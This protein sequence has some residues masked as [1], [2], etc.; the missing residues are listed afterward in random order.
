M[1]KNLFLTMTLG[2]SAMLASAQPSYDFSKMQRESLGRGVIA[3]RQDTKSVF[4][5][6]RYLEQDCKETSFNVYREGKL[7]NASPIKDVTWF[8]D[9]NDSGEPVR[10][11]VRAVVNGKE[12]SA[13]GQNAQAN[14][15]TFTLPVDAPHG[16][17]NLPL[18]VPADGQTPDGKIY[19]YTPNDASIGDVDGDGEYEIILKWDPSNAHD[20]AH[21]GYT[22]NVLFDCYK[23]TGE[24]LWRIDLGRNVRAGAHYTQF[25][26]YDFDGDGRA[27]VIM[28]TG[29]GTKD[30]KGKIIG[31]ANANWVEPGDPN[32]VRAGDFPKGD[33]RG[34]DN[35]NGPMRNQGR[36]LTGPEYL[37]VFN[38]KTG[39]AMAT[40]DYVPARGNL[41]DWGDERANRSDRFLAAVA[42][43]DGVHPS[44]VM[45][46]G[47]YTR[48]VL[49]AWDWDG[50]QLKQRWVFDSYSN[51]Y[52]DYSGQGN[53]NLRVG[54]VDGDGC[55]EILYGACAI[56]HNGQGLYS[57]KM[58]HGDAMHLTG[59][60]PG[61]SHLQVWDCHE[62]RRD[63][64][65]LHDAA[66]GKVL[67]QIPSKM[68]VGRAMAADIDPTNYGVEMWTWDSHGIRNYKGDSIAPCPGGFSCNSAVWWDGDLNRELF[69]RVSREDNAAVLKY[70]AQTQRLDTLFMIEGTKTINGTKGVPCL[71]GDLFG[72][73]REE[74]LLRSDDNRSL[75]LYVST[76]PTKYRFHSFLSD[77]VYRISIATQ[78][79]AYNQPTQPGFYFG[80]DLEGEFRGTTVTKQN[81]LLAK[82]GL[83]DVNGVRDVTL[84]SLNLANTVR[85]VAGSSRKGN[86]PVLFLVGNSTMRTGTLGNGN[87]G[88]WGWGYFEHEYFDETKIT[89]ENHALGGMS[90]RTFYRRLWP[91]VLKGVQAGDYVII[92]LG[93]NDNGP[94]DEGRARASIPGVGK[95]SLVVT[96]KETGE[97]ETVYTYGEYLRRYIRE[98]KSKGAHPIIFS[99]TPRNSWDNETTL[100]RKWDTF[101]PWGKQVAAE[102]GVPHIDLEAI[103]AQKFEK[104]GPA[105]VNYMFYLDKIHTSEFGARTNARSAAEGIAACS[106]SDLRNYLLP[107]DLPMA[108]VQREPGKPVLFLCGDSTMKN[109]DKDEDGMW[110]W[111][112]VAD[113]AFD[114][115]KITIANCGMA[116]RS[117][118]TFLDEGRWDKVYNALQPGD[119]VVIQFGHNDVGD[120]NVK[121]AR[122]VIRG[123]ADS[124][125][126]YSMEPTRKYQVIYTFG[127]Y[128]RKFIGDV[129]EKGATP[130][131]VSLT[132]R[133]E[134]PDGKIERRNDSYGQWFR[135][136]VEQ[137]GVD[138][139]DVHNISAD[140]L[141][142][143]GKEKAKA[144]YNT[145]H[146]HTSKLGAQNNAQS[147]AKGLRVL[148]HPLAKYLK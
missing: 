25:M 135:E 74:L 83:A 63:G 31:D 130:I 47:Y 114:P 109:A 99:L 36:I 107:L 80:S 84:D 43:L 117:T 110:G 145:D 38:G 147:L 46:R 119:F 2:A 18:Q 44:A 131:L 54:D 20:N 16:Y 128:L 15:G 19:T 60:I 137:T 24:K 116:G 103:T 50:K 101:T 76:I 108:D 62:N 71:Q 35:P 13:K 21:D 28:K 4:V 8:V 102:E 39:A 34:K 81:A 125:H 11:E 66:T 42:Y 7:L 3:V 118:R 41:A 70:N 86:N 96:I 104:F 17:I 58:G 141:D 140:F 123:T 134:W 55:D 138:F 146:T 53:H 85:P 73:W 52:Q 65:E 27:E 100:T 111:G 9:Q 121:K 1:N 139:V 23:L 127:W 79:V 142:G 77:P 57:M 143:I 136:V 82:G 6:W 14:R 106:E 98:V 29:D 93:H 144:Y 49:A 40:V 33:P 120:I 92:E 48:A 78:N 124:S 105:K 122:G 37:T 126:V 75:R 90:S 87:N 129:R 132:P 64:S 89:V 95:D 30:G 113:C 67:F 51:G 12:L 133:N 69:D 59:F 5:S 32:G 45:C 94:Y 88:Q 22:G 56:D 148:N 72:D 68:D 10:Y 91:D 115:A 61:D 26:V 97:E 112:S